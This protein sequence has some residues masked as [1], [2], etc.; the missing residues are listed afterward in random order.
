MAKNNET[1]NKSL[2]MNHSTASGRLI[3]DILFKFITKDGILCHHCQEE[4]T[5]DNFSIEHITPWLHAENSLDLFF[6]LNN[7]S[8]AHLK[9]NILKRRL[10]HAKNRTVDELREFWALKKR[11]SYTPE[12]RKEKY[13]KTGY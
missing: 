13:L 6:D 4:M 11:N 10:T 1:K 8:F 9:C 12:K 3:K 7:V 2:G 5:R